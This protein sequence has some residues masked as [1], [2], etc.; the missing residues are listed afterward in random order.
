M[1]FSL[2]CLATALVCGAFAPSLT[3][4]DPV[5]PDGVV[6]EQ[7]VEYSN[8]DDQ[9]LQ[10]NIAR[11]KEG[12][13]PFPTVLCIHGGGW[14]GGHRKSYNAQCLKLA[15][16]GYVAATVSYRL[17]PKY[18]FPAA[19][20]DCKA[21]VRWLRANAEKFHIDPNRI[22][23]MGGSAGGHLSQFLGVTNG[24]RSLEG[25]GG[26]AEQSS[27]VACVVNYF[28]PTDMAGMWGTSV[29]AKQALIPFL[30]GDSITA[31]RNHILS[32]PIS[33][34]TPDAA[35]TLCIQGT[36]DT[37]VPFEQATLFVNRMKAAD[38]EI[39]LLLIEGAGHGFGGEDAVRAAKATLA[40]FDKHLKPKPEA[41]PAQ[42]PPAVAK[43]AEARPAADGK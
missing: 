16:Q 7:N 22:G 13:G 8:P 18:P 37:L 3:A 35:P 38:V 36:R 26:N 4:A 30:G 28:G 27:D 1:R 42:D 15:E 20:H 9:H 5:V 19:I 21:A 39:D 33:W 43:P 25:T 14:V 6:F 11:P 34:V 23:V 12:A 2:T 29:A 32:S 41:S 10:L 40:F 17:A 31:R 24:V